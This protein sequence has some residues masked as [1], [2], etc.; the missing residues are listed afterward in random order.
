MECRTCKHWRCY[1]GHRLENSGICNHIET[2]ICV[3][4]YGEH[5][6]VSC[7]TEIET[8]HDFFCKGHVE[9]GD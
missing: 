5:E 7:Y 9:K 3:D 1:G 8:P 6:G 4:S 2:L